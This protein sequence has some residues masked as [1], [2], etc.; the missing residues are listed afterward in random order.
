MY[1]EHF[2][3]IHSQKTLTGEVWSDLCGIKVPSISCI[4]MGHDG[5]SWWRHQMETFPALLSL[6]AGNAPVTGEFPAQRPVTRSF[7]VFLICLWINDWVN[8]REA[9]DLRHH[10]AHYEVTVMY[11]EVRRCLSLSLLWFQL[12]IMWNMYL[13]WRHFILRGKLYHRKPMDSTCSNIQTKGTRCMNCC[14]LFMVAWYKLFLLISHQSE[15]FH[16]RITVS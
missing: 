7:N 16:I 5:C 2:S 10:C 3:P 15:R 8:N 13:P 9:G 4:C 11:I 1:L 6:C 12:R 14:F